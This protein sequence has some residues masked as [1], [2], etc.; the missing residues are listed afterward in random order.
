MRAWRSRLPYASSL[1]SAE[2]IVSI[3]PLME[4][5]KSKVLELASVQNVAFTCFSS[6]RENS[7]SSWKKH[8]KA[9]ASGIG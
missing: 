1:I 6:G 5:R 9:S 4:D 7:G 2:Y 3:I 8:H